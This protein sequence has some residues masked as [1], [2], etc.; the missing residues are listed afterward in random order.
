MS[1]KRI[2]RESAT[3][4]KYPDTVPQASPTSTLTTDAA[5]PTA[6]EMRPA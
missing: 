1:T 2:I 3:P 6:S 5:S 4:P